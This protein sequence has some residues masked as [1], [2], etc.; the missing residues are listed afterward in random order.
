MRV[1]ISK[2]AE[3]ELDEI[4]VYIA[5]DNPERAAA[6]VI[7]IVDQCYALA[8]HSRRYPVAIDVK[9]LQLRRCPFRGYLI[10]YAITDQVEIAHIIH[11]A[12]DYLKVLFPE[13]N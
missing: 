8:K 1:H 4:G 2:T 3:R 13:E 6:F 12:R 7:E 9:G 5:Q 11:A 10:F